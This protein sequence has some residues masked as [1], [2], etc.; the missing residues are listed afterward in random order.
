MIKQKGQ[1][2]IQLKDSEAFEYLRPILEN[3]DLS[4]SLD[5]DE[6]VN[7][8]L[9]AFG[10]EGSYQEFKIEVKFADKSSMDFKCKAEEKDTEREREREREREQECETELPY[11]KFELEIESKKRKLEVEIEQEDGRISAKM[12]SSHNGTKDS[13][14]KGSAA[15]EYLLPILKKLDLNAS[16]SRQQ[17]MDRV[18]AAFGWEGFYEEFEIKVKLKNGSTLDFEWEYDDYDNDNDDDDDDD[19]D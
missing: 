10:W 12:E 16:M 15:L 11:K 3:L 19:D 9:N 13:E 7:R 6:F 4:V 2:H 14:L 5:K 8:V 18:V 1:K 17:V